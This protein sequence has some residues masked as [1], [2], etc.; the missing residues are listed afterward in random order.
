M[1]WG[2]HPDLL[3]R[4]RELDLLVAQVTA[5]DQ[6]LQVVLDDVVAPPQQLEELLHLL[7]VG[8]VEQPEGNH[9]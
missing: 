8:L 2:T 6:L 1:R 9:L 7:V 4:G 5:E 3:S